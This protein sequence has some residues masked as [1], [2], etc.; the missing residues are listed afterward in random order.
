MGGKI[1]MM[2]DSSTFWSA[3]DCNICWD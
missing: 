3:I 2:A 1:E